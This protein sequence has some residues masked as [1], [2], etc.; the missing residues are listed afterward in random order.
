MLTFLHTYRPSPILFKLGILAIHWYGLLIAIAVIIGLFLTIK[1]TQKYRIEKEKIF[2]LAFYLIIFGFFGARI[3]HVLSEIN[4]Y[5]LHPLE[6][7]YVWQGGLG[8][9]G[10][11][12]VG[13]IV[14]FF[15]SRKHQLSFWLIADILVP[16]FVLGEAIVRWGNWFNQENFGR[17]T[18]LPWGIPIDWQNRPLEYLNSEYFHPCFLYQFLWNLVIFI[19]LIVLI[20]KIKFGSGLILSIYLITYSIG[21]FLIEFLRINYQPIFLGL[22]LAQVMTILIF[23]FGV[24]LLI[25]KLSTKNS[26]II[27]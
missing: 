3:Y 27:H 15:Y 13:I 8:V 14:L 19:F 22:R 21:R 12:I 11:L 23:L 17:P 9:F 2:D 18:N 6:I 20:K 5:R 7:F 16:S 4:Y 24:L 25:I 26:Q 10:A 1:F